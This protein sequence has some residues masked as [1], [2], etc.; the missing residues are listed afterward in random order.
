MWTGVNLVS[1]GEGVRLLRTWWAISSVIL[2][3]FSRLTLVDSCLLV[4]PGVQADFNELMLSEVR[5]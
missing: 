3:L 5:E 1:G 4:C 2:S